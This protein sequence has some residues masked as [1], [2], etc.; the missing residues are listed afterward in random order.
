[1]KK[2]AIAA[3][4]KNEEI[5]VDRWLQQSVDADY[6]FVL[7][8]GSTD[9]T[10]KLLSDGKSLIP[11]KLFVE[12]AS[13][14]EIDYSAFRNKLL[15]SLLVLCSDV[16]YILYIDMD[17]VLQS[18]WREVLDG[19]L[20]EDP[21]SLRIYRTELPGNW[22]TPLSRC[23]KNLPG[24]WIKPLHEGFVFDEYEGEELHAYNFR[25]DHHSNIT[26][27]K[28]SRYLSIIEKNLDTSDE[29]LYFYFQHVY[30]DFKDYPRVIRMYDEMH[31]K[32]NKLSDIFRHL[33]YRY[34][35]VSKR[36]T[37]GDLDFDL[38]YKY[39]EIRNKSTLFTASKYCDLHGYNNEAR[40]LFELF[41]VFKEN[42]ESKLKS[43][44]PDAYDII[45]IQK[46]KENIFK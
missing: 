40:M 26:P 13:F 17:E 20:E 35:L 46:L 16:E 8:T 45:A 21:P 27:E 10:L 43:Y 9:N 24:K 32:V 22:I 5:N 1:M 4:C 12:S 36:L 28:I 30:A 37:G 31:N 25:I 6:V 11:N 33:I 15:E 34:V 44:M 3:I 41:E 29:Y 38:L 7:D 23:F 2:V 18:G 42:N 14:D 19:Y 39:L